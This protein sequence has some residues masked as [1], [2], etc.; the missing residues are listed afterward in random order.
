MHHYDSVYGWRTR[1]ETL[2]L[3]LTGKMIKSCTA[4]LWE[5]VIGK[6]RST[7]TEQMKENLLCSINNFLCITKSYNYCVIIVLMLKVG[8]EETG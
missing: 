6:N 2:V 4:E 5:R 3:Q 1:S 8:V 7:G